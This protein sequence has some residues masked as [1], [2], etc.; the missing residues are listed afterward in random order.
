MGIKNAITKFFRSYTTSKSYVFN[1]KK[2]AS[3]DDMPEEARTA[4]ERLR[5]GSPEF[6]IEK[7]VTKT[8][9]EYNGKKY[10]SLEDMPQEIQAL[11]EDKDGNGIPD[12]FEN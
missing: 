10:D 1:G 3:L 8:T 6:E 12:G 4:F 9:Y 7:T 11:L 2:Y 5:S